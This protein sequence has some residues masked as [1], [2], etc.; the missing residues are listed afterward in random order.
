MMPT[1]SE[2]SDDAKGRPLRVSSGV[3]T[4]V[5]SPRYSSDS[6]ALWQA[7]LASRWSTTRVRQLGDAAE[8]VGAVDPAEVLIYG[9][10]ILAD[11]VAAALDL[12]LLEPTYAWLPELPAALRL[13]EIA[14]TTLGAARRLAGPVFVKPVDDKFFPARVYAPVEVDAIVADD[15][16]V[17]I[18]E[19]VRF[20]V[21]VRAFVCDRAVVGMSAYMRGGQL[22]RTEA[23]DWPLG[24]DEE[25]AA[26]AC[27]D[28]LLHSDVALPPAVV[29]DVG[30]I[31]D[32]GWAIVEANPAWA[33]GLC[34]VDA[35]AVLPVLRR[36]CMPRA[37]LGA[38]E[39][40]WVRPRAQLVRV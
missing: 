4:L 11:A 35:R 10:T 29:I 6:I 9:E 36:A 13:R 15:L 26:R 38:A 40:P 39:L 2:M 22:A 30:E 21:E 12:A 33:S 37:S 28:R 16:P 17:L 32:R 19:P 1:A 23:G 27:L 7:A 34:G 5:L 31:V 20:G 8:L 14:L 24:P 25:S 3:P 18:A